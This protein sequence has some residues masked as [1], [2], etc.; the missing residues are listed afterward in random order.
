MAYIKINRQAREGIIGNGIA[1]GDGWK[2]ATRTVDEE[3]RGIRR[4]EIFVDVAHTEKDIGI[5]P[6]VAIAQHGQGRHIVVGFDVGKGLLVCPDSLFG[7]GH[8]ERCRFKIVGSAFY[9]QVQIEPQQVE[10]IGFLVCVPLPF[11]GVTAAETLGETRQ[12]KETAGQKAKAEK[13]FSDIHWFH[14]T[15]YLK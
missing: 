3:R 13:G 2:D 15:F 4:E 1:D 12:S 14:E 8:V 6:G 9:R 7:F 5:L 10:P 11:G